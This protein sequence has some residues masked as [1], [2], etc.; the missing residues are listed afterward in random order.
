MQLLTAQQTVIA[1]LQLQTQ[2]NHTVQIA[3]TDGLRSLAESTQQRNFDHIFFSMQ[4]YG[5]TNKEGFFKW[6][7]RLEA[8]CFQSRRD[9]HTEAL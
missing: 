4:M 8:T 7:E 6:I 1:Q 9:I 3:Y 2:Q 5:G